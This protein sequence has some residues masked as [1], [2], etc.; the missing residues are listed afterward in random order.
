MSQ[1][2]Y[3]AAPPYSQAQQ[4]MVGYQGGFGAAPAQPLYVHYGGP[5]QAQNAPPTGMMKPAAS[6]PAGMLPPPASTQ[7][8][9]NVQQ[10]GGHP[11]SM[12]SAAPPP[13]QQLTN[14][15]SAMNLGGY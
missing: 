5:P 6:S 15:M 14:Q 8:N 10:N 11:Q 4:G 2:G 12:T 13:T 1:Q 3:V 9:P 7:Y